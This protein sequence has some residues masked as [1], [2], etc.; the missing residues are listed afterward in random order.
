MGQVSIA[1]AQTRKLTIFASGLPSGSSVR[2]VQGVVDYAG[3]AAPDPRTSTL[4]A[5][6]ASAF[7]TGARTVTVPSRQATF[8]RVE[9]LS[10][11]GGLV[12]AGSNP[13]WALPVAPPPGRT[14]PGDRL[15]A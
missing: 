4:A 13:I 9:V 10:A 5:L 12:L 3:G 6:P 2:V 11:S 15:H 14:I 7:S 8:V 1:R